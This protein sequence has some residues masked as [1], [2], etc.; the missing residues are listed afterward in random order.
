MTI[1]FGDKKH[2]DIISARKTLNGDIEVL[3]SNYSTEK[4]VHLVEYEL[5]WFV[6]IEKPYREPDE[7]EI[8]GFQSYPIENQLEAYRL[9]ASL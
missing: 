6:V 2:L 1:I 9:N 3:S 5:E 8:C 4:S 7:P